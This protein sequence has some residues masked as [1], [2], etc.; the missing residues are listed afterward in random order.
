MSQDT[1]HYKDAI[2]NMFYDWAYHVWQVAAGKVQ[3]PDVPD[4]DA[5]AIVSV[6]VKL[7]K[8]IEEDAAQIQPEL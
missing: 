4:H 8:Q 5:F 2:S 3:Q 7:E 6:M 1:K